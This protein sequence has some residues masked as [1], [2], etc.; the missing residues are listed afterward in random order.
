MPQRPSIVATKTCGAE[1]HVFDCG[2]RPP[3]PIEG[4]NAGPDLVLRGHATE[5]Y[6]VVLESPQGGLSLERILRFQY[7]FVGLE[8]VAWHLKNENIF[9]SVGDDHLLMIWDLRSSSL[10]KP[11]H[12]VTAHEDEVKQL[13]WECYGIIV[14]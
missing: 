2:Q 13:S 11:Q 1:V 10:K 6:G 7:L 12:L 4:T 9:G 8:D 3:R 5:G 14:V